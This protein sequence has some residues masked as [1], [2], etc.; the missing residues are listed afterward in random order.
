MEEDP[1]VSKRGPWHEVSGSDSSDGEP[2]LISSG[3][4]SSTEDEADDEACPR[5]VALLYSPCTAYSSIFA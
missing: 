1:T 2:I 4:A 5:S 3:D